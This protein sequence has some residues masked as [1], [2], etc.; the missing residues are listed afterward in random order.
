[1]L[2]TINSYIQKG[3]ITL[4][5]MWSTGINTFLYPDMDGGNHK[6]IESWQPFG[7]PTLAIAK[8]SQPPL[9]PNI[10][11]GPTSSRV[12]QENTYSTST[13]DPDDDHLYY[14]FSWGDNQ[15]SG[16]IGP[17]DSTENVQASHTWTEAGNYEIK[18]KA[19][20]QHG[21]QSQ[22]S[23]TLNVNVTKGKIKREIILPFF[24]KN[25]FHIFLDLFVILRHYKLT[26]R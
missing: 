8:E 23:D 15:N 7:D 25:L 14:L 19:K 16:W 9:K 21:V 10:P 26:L 12:N 2:D 4:G 20:D 5:E 13:I 22:W 17:Y 1:M 11:D 24:Q 6:S 18:V 3:A